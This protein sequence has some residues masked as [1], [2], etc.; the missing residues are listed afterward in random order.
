MT[1][2]DII[3]FVVATIGVD[4]NTARDR[5]RAFA[6]ARWK[7]VWNHAIWRQSRYHAHVAIPAGA[8]LVELPSEFDLVHAVRL[9]ADQMLAPALDIDA[10]FLDPAGRDQPGQPVSFAVMG[11]TPA[12]RVQLRLH[13]PPN[14]TT[15]LLVLGKLAPSRLT[16]DADTPMG[17]P[18]VEECLCAFVL[19][20]LQRWMRQYGKA[21]L[22]YRE[23]NALLLKCTEIET[24]QNAETRRLLPGNVQQLEGEHGDT[25][26]WLR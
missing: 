3:S 16:E 1:L 25:A 13:R 12:G 8:E 11:K 21:D 24:H 7:M 14:Q 10:L 4:D 22:H 18:G 5:A 19:G 23:A 9:G 6:A 20:D 2:A 17:I 15:T 26:D